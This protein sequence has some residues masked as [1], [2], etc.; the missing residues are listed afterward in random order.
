VFPLAFDAIRFVRFDG[1]VT[2][3]PDTTRE[4]GLLAA[5]DTHIENMCLVCCSCLVSDELHEPPPAPAPA[6]HPQA[7]AAQ[8]IARTAGSAD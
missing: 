2:C 5:A 6:A 1:T 4:V 7:M 3:T 8:S